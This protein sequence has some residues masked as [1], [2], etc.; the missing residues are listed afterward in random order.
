MGLRECI[1]L[2]IPR[3]QTDAPGL[4][5]DRM[6]PLQLLWTLLL[7]CIVFSYA[8]ACPFLLIVGPWG[9]PARRKLKSHHEKLHG[10]IQSSKTRI[11][12]ILSAEIILVCLATMVAALMGCLIADA[13]RRLVEV[14]RGEKPVDVESGVRAT[15][16]Q[17][18]CHCTRRLVLIPGA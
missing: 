6:T 12:G 4:R 8:A 15:R 2:H 3:H 5:R 11:D 1:D 14:S 7:R 17:T 18:A 10:P 13:A 16:P 9:P